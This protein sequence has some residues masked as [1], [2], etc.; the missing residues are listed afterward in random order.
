VLA[1]FSPPIGALLL[2]VGALFLATV[3]LAIF[4]ILGFAASVGAKEGHLGAWAFWTLIW[5]AVLPI[6]AARLLIASQWARRELE[7]R[8]QTTLGQPSNNEPTAW[9]STKQWESVP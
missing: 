6:F 2:C 4:W 7:E 3:W 1:W 5:W 8:Q 9:G